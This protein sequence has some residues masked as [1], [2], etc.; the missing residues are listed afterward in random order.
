MWCITEI[1]E[2]YRKRMYRVLDLYKKPF[3]PEYPVVCFDEKSKQLLEDSRPPIP[4]SAGH[5]QKYDYE[6]RRN[7][8]CN[9]RS[10]DLRKTYF[11]NL[12]NNDLIISD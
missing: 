7:G 4:L 11:S 3:N 10:T 5:V 8:T 9:I 6:Y 1:T 12:I 2:E